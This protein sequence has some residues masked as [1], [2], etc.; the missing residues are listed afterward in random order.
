MTCP[1][2]GRAQ[3]QDR[4]RGCGWKAPS[5]Q[6]VEAAQTL[7][8]ASPCAFRTGTWQ[9]RW[10]RW[11]S[12]PDDLVFCEVHA[13]GLRVG[14]VTVDDLFEIFWGM[15][16][17][18]QARR[19]VDRLACRDGRGGW[20]YG[21]APPASDPHAAAPV[22]RFVPFWWLPVEVA[23]KILTG[24]EVLPASATTVSPPVVRERVSA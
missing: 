15:R 16:V 11:S 7:R 17:E 23:W 9:C 1:E 10:A 24:Y 12:R 13:E 6:Q 2:C 14:V 20:L 22:G 21:W 3:V 4:C 19:S 8:D 5:A 18:A